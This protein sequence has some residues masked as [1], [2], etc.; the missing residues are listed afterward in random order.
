MTARE[1]PE[2]APQVMARLP[3]SGGHRERLAKI[4]APAEVVF[5]ER[6]DHIAIA[7]A[8][9]T[10]EVALIDGVMDDRYLAAPKL[11]WVHCDQSGLDGYAPQRL[12]DSDL[13]VTSS[14]GRSGPVLAEHAVFFMLSLIY[15]APKLARAQRRRVWGIRDQDR[16]RG[17]N[18]RSISIIGYGAT[19]ECLARQCQSFD[20]NIRA[21]RRKDVPADVPGIRMYSAERGDSLLDAVQ[22]ADFVVMCASLN[23]D[24]HRM[25]GTDEIAAMA[26][27]SYLINVARAQLVDESAMISGLK[28]GHLAGA[29]LDVTDPYEPLPPWHRLWSVPNMMITPHFT[30]QMPDRTSRTLDIVEENYARYLKGD[31]L[32]HRFSSDDVFSYAAETGQFRGRHRLLSAW[33]RFGR[34]IG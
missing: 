7:K 17:L 1:V 12:S 28:S 2:A 13:V 31:D 20:M 29:G 27:G 30:P 33:N 32:L 16:L 15:R 34:W 5:V 3:W 10:C 18:G 24:S 11:K 23:D 26:P 8:L 14:K 19:G 4:F 22:G 9:Q 21:Y 6:D 25:L